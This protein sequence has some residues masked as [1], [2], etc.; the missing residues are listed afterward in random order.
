M[1]HNRNSL[2]HF[3]IADKRS[4][5]IIEFFVIAVLKEEWLIIIFY[6]WISKRLLSYSVFYILSYKLNEIAG[7]KATCTLSS[8]P[9]K[10]IGDNL[11]FW[12]WL[13]CKYSFHMSFL[14]AEQHYTMRGGIK[15][16][17]K[18][19]QNAKKKK[20]IKIYVLV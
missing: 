3:K 16:I 10:S 19:N 12:L 17:T 14:N 5:N 6:D 4:W 8:L 1:I 9:N 11:K 15:Q 18:W 2:F 20:N 7:R 13:M